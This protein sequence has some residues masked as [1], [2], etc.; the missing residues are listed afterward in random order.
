MGATAIIAFPWVVAYESLDFRRKFITQ[1]K[2][3]R[4]S[5]L[6]QIFIHGSRLITN[7]RSRGHE[8]TNHKFKNL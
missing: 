3:A 7:I 1:N 8:K 2:M 4:E 5:R 6:I